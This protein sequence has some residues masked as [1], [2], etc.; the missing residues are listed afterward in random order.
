MKQPYRPRT[1]RKFIGTYR[2]RID[3]AEK[4]SGQAL[5]IDDLTLKSKYPDLLYCRVLRSPYP[6]ARILKMDVSRAEK[7]PGVRAIL[8]YKDPEFTNLK[9]TSAGWT[10][11]VDTVSYDRMMWGHFRD[12]R[13]L[14]D[15]ACWVTDEI[16]AVVAADEPAVLPEEV[17]AEALGA[18][19][20]AA[21]HEDVLGDPDQ[22]AHLLGQF[23]D[24]RWRKRLAPGQPVQELGGCEG[25]GLGEDLGQRSFGPSGATLPMEMR[26]GRLGRHQLH[27]ARQVV[28]GPARQGRAGPRTVTC[29][30]T[31][32][33]ADHV[34][35]P[36]PDLPVDP[37]RAL[38]WLSVQ[39]GSG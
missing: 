13:V 34:E 39:D 36:R 28:V 30:P 35:H 9:A 11:G 21:T 4:A 1:P 26:D 24:L 23:P 18:D 37:I 10:D 33:R 8:T 14:G 12:R 6:H 7:F 22:P 3:G 32:S 2:P 19:P 38:R 27:P 16:G 31:R 15:K 17:P 25:L 20:P 29:W 5:F